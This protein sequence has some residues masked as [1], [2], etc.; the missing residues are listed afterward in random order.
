MRVEGREQRISHAPT[1]E[2]F[3]GLCR[4]VGQGSDDP[5]TRVG[6]VVVKRTIV[7]M[8]GCNTFPH[9]VGDPTGV[10]SIRP[11]K[12]NWIE[13]AERN[14]I[15]SAAKTGIA[16]ENATIYVELMPCV[17]CARAIIQAGIS[18]VVVSADRM[19]RYE[20]DKY[21]TQHVLAETMLREAGVSVR[22]V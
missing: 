11:E 15:Y 4:E 6:C 18:E 5:D 16:L 21:S 1:D 19:S 14:A 9:G 20:S 22:R 2:T 10:R 7:L 3:L 13:H 12:Y 8:R 17:E